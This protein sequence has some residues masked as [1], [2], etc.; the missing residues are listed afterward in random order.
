VQR[1]RSRVSLMDLLNAGVIKPGATLRFYNR[2][3]TLAEVTSRG[4]VLFRG[5]EYS[6]LSAAGSAV[7]NHAVNGWEAWHV[8]LLDDHWI[9]ITELRPPL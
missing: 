4:T 8:M 5:V 6:S 1:G 9:K 2:E 7:T 3:D